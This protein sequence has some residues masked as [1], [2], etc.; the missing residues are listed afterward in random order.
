[1]VARAGLKD[2]GQRLSGQD[3]QDGQDVSVEHT[4]SVAVSASR[5]AKFEVRDYVIF[6][7]RVLGDP[8]C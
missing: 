7:E 6:A 4:V 5:G 8:L 3:G 2:R 1:M